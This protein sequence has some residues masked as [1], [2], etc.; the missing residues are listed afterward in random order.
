MINAIL[1]ILFQLITGSTDIRE[2]VKEFHDLKTEK[3]EIQFI[4]KYKQSLDPSVLAY[5]VS[6]AM[7][8]AEYSYNPYYKIKIFKTNKK[9]LNTLLN[10]NKSNIH[11]RY[12][13][14]V[15]QENAPSILGYDDYI[16]EDKA[17][18]KKKLDQK[19]KIDYLDKYIKANTSL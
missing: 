13:R 11:L 1:L 3:S 10:S 9:K 5:V 15:A 16:M 4:E 2:V 19:D 6:I 14:L 7:K 17:F 18:L 12:V 8:Q